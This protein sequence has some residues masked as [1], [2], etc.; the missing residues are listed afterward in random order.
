MARRAWYGVLAVAPVFIKPDRPGE[1]GDGESVSGT[2]R[3]VLRNGALFAPLHAAR[4]NVEG[5]RHCSNTHH[6]H[7]ALGDRPRTPESRT[8]A[9]LSLPA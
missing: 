9:A 8:F 1:H 5:W 7:R 3:D 2:L 6:P 4:V